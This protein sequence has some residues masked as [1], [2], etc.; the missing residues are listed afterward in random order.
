MNFLY[1]IDNVLMSD[2][3]FLIKSDTWR[4]MTFFYPAE[5][6]VY[7]N[8]MAPRITYRYVDGNWQKQYKFYDYL[9]SERFTVLASGQVIN[10][11]QYSAYG[12]T[13]LDTLGFARQGYIGKEKDVEN[14]LGDHGVRKYDTETGRF[15]SADMLWEKFYGWNL[16]QY[17][18][19][20]PIR[21]YDRNGLMPGDPFNDV[22][23]AVLDFAVIYN[24]VSILEDREYSSRLYSFK[25]NDG[26]IYY[27]YTEP[28][29]G[30]S[31]Y[32][33]Y[34]QV[35]DFT[36]DAGVVHTHAAYDPNLSTWSTP[37]G[38]K[39]VNIHLSNGDLY[40][41]QYDHKSPVW[42]IF[43]NGKI[44]MWD[45]KNPLKLNK[46]SS[47]FFL[48]CDVN[49]PKRDGNQNT[50]NDLKNQTDF[51]IKQLPKE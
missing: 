42:G 16:Y 2:Q 12:E 30:T 37:F 29:I 25:S 17:C 20:N 19:N 5:Y 14:N 10:Y 7:G 22:K 11:K 1:Y 13:L 33:Y 31:G 50:V 44:E 24:G 45:P 27:S 28:N 23:S 34:P 8:E 36:K 43:P 3:T 21:Y 47:P 38:G 26:N 18:F 51:L 39:D 40:N 4:P 46:I 6:N 15:N 9:G 49:A 41:A 48:P 35:P 32:V